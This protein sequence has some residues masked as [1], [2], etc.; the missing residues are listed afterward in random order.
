MHLEVRDMAVTWGENTK[1][2]GGVLK[3]LQTQHL[4]LFVTVCVL[5]AQSHLTICDPKIVAHQ[6]LQSM[7]FSRQEYWS[8]LPF[9]S[10]GDLP[11]TGVKPLSSALQADSLPSELP[12]KPYLLLLCMKGKS[13]DIL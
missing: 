8:G 9:P 3:F 10:S 6:A 2:T 4:A 13:L 11:D 12:G 1:C 7:E 5:V